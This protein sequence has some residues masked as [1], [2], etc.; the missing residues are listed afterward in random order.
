MILNVSFHSQVTINSYRSP[1]INHIEGEEGKEEN[2]ENEDSAKQEY[3]EG[4]EVFRD[5]VK[6]SCVINHHVDTTGGVVEARMEP[7][8]FV[9]CNFSRK[10][11]GQ[12]GDGHFSPIGGEL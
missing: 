11:L 12:T 8:F 7:G 9:I 1:N 6:R 5:V 10:V 3:S 4:L 2:K